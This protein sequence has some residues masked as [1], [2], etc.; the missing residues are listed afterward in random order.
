M[1]K[2]SNI[3][4]VIIKVN[5][6]ILV[7]SAP[8]ANSVYCVASHIASANVQIGGRDHA[9]EGRVNMSLHTMLL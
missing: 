5:F 1:P 4:I 2:N 7:V 9:L 6:T 8:F 3:V